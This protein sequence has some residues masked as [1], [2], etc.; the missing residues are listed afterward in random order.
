VQTDPQT[1]AALLYQGRP[2][3]DAL[4]TGDAT[5]SGDTAVVTRFLQLFPLPEK[6][7]TP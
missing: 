3:D 7:S 5:I 2:L 1:L 4:H 6:A